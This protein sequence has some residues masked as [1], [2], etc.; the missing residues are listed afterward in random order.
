MSVRAAARAAPGARGGGSAWGEVAALPRHAVSRMIAALRA[1]WGRGAVR[2]AAAL[3]AAA[4][5]YLL[6]VRWAP[7]GLAAAGGLLQLLA[8]LLIAREAAA[9]RYLAV[10]D[11]LTGL[12]SRRHLE[13][14]LRGA[15]AARRRRPGQP[16]LVLLD[17]DRFKQVNDRLGHAA[18]DRLLAEVA[19]TLAA[20]TR[21]SE[22]L[23]R[24]GGDE[25]ALV[26]PEGD[27]SEAAGAAR[28]LQAAAGAAGVGLS[29]GLA[30]AD[31]GEGPE[32]LFAR[33]DADLY[34]SKRARGGSTGPAG[35]RE[36]AGGCYAL[37]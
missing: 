16:A 9:W 7:V 4:A 30:A 33:A 17:L 5:G 2:P 26:L 13:E 14:R 6:L 8:G 1:L 22:V 21:R 3:R 32:A 24:W 36:A 10:R 25:F 18:G 27:G 11:P 35:V 29:A 12:W 23:G 37:H 20:V 31:G 34:R 15:L 28:R 19:R